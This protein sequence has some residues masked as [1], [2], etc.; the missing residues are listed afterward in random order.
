MHT[1]V[2]CSPVYNSKDFEQTQTPINVRLNKENVVHIYRGI[3]HSHKKNNEFVSFV[4][5]WM[6]LE[7]MWRNRSALTLLVGV[8][9]SSTTVEDNM[10]IPQGSRTRNTI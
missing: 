2:Y 5:T 10:V 9:I 7:N 6:N 8:S 3:L 1:Y 4:G